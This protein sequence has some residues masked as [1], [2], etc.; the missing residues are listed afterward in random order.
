MNTALN[1]IAASIA[2]FSVGLLIFFLVL[3]FA[4]IVM[5]VLGYIFESLAFYRFMENRNLDNAF[6]AWLPIVRHYTIGKVYDDINEKQGKNTNFG[7]ILLVLDGIASF[8][9]LLHISVNGV[10]VIHAPYWSVSF[11]VLILELICF[12]LIFK[13]YAPN[14]SSYFVLTLIFSIIPLVPFIPG[15]CLLKASKNEPVSET[16]VNW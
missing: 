14:N 4:I 5:A 2:G 7:I 9:N 15:L 12:N 8:L 1:G 6:L 13:K 16:K 10:D 11:A 3:I